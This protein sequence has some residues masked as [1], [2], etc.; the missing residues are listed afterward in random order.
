MGGELF[1]KPSKDKL[2]SDQP[3]ECVTGAVG[4]CPFPGGKEAKVMCVERWGKG[5]NRLGK[6]Y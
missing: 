3:G 2:M 5:R 4:V 1:A 6:G